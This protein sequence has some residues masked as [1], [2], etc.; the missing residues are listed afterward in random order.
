[1]GS[2]EYITHSLPPVL[3]SGCICVISDRYLAMFH[4][5]R[6]IRGS[7][8]PVDIVFQCQNILRIFPLKF[9]LFFCNLNSI[10]PVVPTLLYLILW[11]PIFSCLGCE[12][13]KCNYMYTED[14][15][16]FNSKEEAVDITVYVYPHKATPP[17]CLWHKARESAMT[18][19]EK[20]GACGL[21]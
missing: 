11:L 21:Q 10:L 2:R 17:L 8:A 6:N 5:D 18:S 15:M 7:T 13:L 12:M 20:T 19:G 3:P 14:S 9:D 4:N 1:M 16:P